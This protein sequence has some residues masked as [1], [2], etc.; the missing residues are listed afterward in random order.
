MLMAML[1]LVT[2]MLVAMALI[3][4]GVPCVMRRV[5]GF[6]RHD[7][8]SRGTSGHSEHQTQSN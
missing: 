7:N 6:W 1:V 3:M 5:R 2:A 8:S 4:H